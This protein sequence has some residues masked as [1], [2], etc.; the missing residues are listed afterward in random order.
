MRISPVAVLLVVALTS[1]GC[2]DDSGDSGGTSSPTPTT[3]VTSP[4][5]T[6]S[7]TSSPSSAP[8]STSAVSVYFLKGEKV[9]PVRRSATGTGVAAAAVRALLAG[10][11]SAERAAGLTSSVPS[12]TTL[13]SLD[14]SGGLATVD[15]TGTFDDGGGS[16]SM[17]ARVAQ[18]VFTLTRFTSVQRVSFR[19]DGTP[20]TALGGEGVDVDKVDRA[21]YEDLSPAVLVESPRWGETVTMPLTVT[22]TA[23]TFEAEFRLELKDST[24][25]VVADRQV[26]ATSGSGTRGTFDATLTGTAARGAATLTAYTLSAQDGSRRNESVVRLTL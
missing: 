12:G 25:R 4:P 3:A 26:M 21:D 11:T 18:V 19:L 1:A 10:P 8:T 16:L 2:G 20:V 22:G 14:I 9:Q 23:N 15:L 13:R 7:P 17:Q 24:G 5:P 6:S